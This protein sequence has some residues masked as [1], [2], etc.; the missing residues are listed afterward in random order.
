VY[1]CRSKEAFLVEVKTTTT[2]DESRTF[3]SKAKLDDYAKYWAEAILVMHCLRSG[4]LYCQR[5]G[6]INRSQLRINTQFDHPLY[7]LNLKKDFGG[8][9]DVFNQ[10]SLEAD[11]YLQLYSSI[12]GVLREFGQT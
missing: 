10:L 11:K 1:D 6:D 3:I 2:K 9:P 12:R 5:I 7:E 4:N 8:L